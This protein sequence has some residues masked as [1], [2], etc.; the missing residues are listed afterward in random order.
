MWSTQTNQPIT[1]LCLIPL[2][3]LSTH[4]IAVGLK[5][6]SLQLFQGRQTVDY[7]SVPDAACAACFGQL[8]QEEHVLVVITAAGTLNFKILKRTADFNL[9]PR[10]ANASPLFQNKPLPLPK[11]SKLFLEQSMR[12]K[13]NPTEMHQNFQQDLV[14]LRLAA[15]RA[16][17]QNL[18]DQTGIGNEKEQIKLSAQVLGLG[19]KFTLILAIENMN[20]EEGLLD[21]FVVFQ[22]DVALY[23]LS[24]YFVKVIPVF[25]C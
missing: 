6:G 25:I 18:A 13:Q 7:V 8:G 23:K 11:R 14:R 24:R 5:G 4:L 15:A 22:V 10:D 9:P 1:C 20:F 21:V 19:P 2:K 3:H 16:L 12:E 17:V